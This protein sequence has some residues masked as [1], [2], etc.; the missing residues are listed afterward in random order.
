[1]DA[2][3]LANE[4]RVD[5]YES[6]DLGGFF[7][8]SCCPRCGGPLARWSEEIPCCGPPSEC[9]DTLYYVACDHCRIVGDHF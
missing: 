2:I 3:P 8:G 4:L 1:M 6:I 9:T 5:S 7:T